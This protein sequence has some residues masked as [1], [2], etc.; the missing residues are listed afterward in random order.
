MD[1]RRPAWEISSSSDSDSDETFGPR[2]A[3]KKR[4]RPQVVG[5]RC[6]LRDN[7]LL[8]LEGPS[9]ESA[10]R[11]VDVLANMVRN[12]G[13]EHSCFVAKMVAEIGMQRPD[14]EVVCLVQNFLGRDVFCL[15]KTAEAAHRAK[16]SYRTFR[17]RLDVLAASI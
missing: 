11:V 7:N 16:M 9:Q 10:P 12:T 1:H 6:W 4:G 2:P 15:A 13:G 3:A 14:P 5:G 17:R 8:Q